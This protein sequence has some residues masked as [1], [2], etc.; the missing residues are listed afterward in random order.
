VTQ[1]NREKYNVTTSRVYIL[2]N[3]VIHVNV[4]D[5]YSKNESNQLELGLQN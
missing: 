4:N 1:I 3:N 5:N 2:A